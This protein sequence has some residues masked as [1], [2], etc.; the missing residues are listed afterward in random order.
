MPEPTNVQMRKA[1]GILVEITERKHHL[2]SLGVDDRILTLSQ[3]TTY[4]YD[5]PHS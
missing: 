3:L 2:N 5:V 4:M 1:Y